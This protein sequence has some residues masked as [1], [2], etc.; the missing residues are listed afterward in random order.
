VCGLTFDARRAGRCLEQPHL[1][2]EPVPLLTDDAGIVKVALPAGVG[3][4]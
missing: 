2:L 4:E 1:S 3:W